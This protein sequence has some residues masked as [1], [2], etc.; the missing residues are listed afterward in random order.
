MALAATCLWASLNEIKPWLRLNVDDVRDDAVLEVLANSVTEEIERI[1]ARV[2]V[3]R[4]ITE[5]FDSRHT[6]GAQRGASVWRFVLSG[7]PVST[8]PL[9]TFTIDGASV[10]VDDYILNTTTGVVR[11][12]NSYSSEDGIGDVV[13][14]YTA[15]YARA[16][17][18]VT[19]VQLGIEMLA[20]RYQDWNAGANAAA[21]IQIGSQTYTPRSSWS[22]HIL[23]GLNDLRREVRGGVVA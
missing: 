17:L 18:P 2:W 21:A 13:I 15:G 4:A 7:Y 10:D 22:Y 8:A 16:S 5:R 12:L 11:L 1:T 23:D 20:I 6:A 9:T 3:S 14:T 19:V